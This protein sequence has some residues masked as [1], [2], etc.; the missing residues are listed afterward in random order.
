MRHVQGIMGCCTDR[1]EGWWET[2]ALSSLDAGLT[3]LIRP[4]AARRG[5]FSPEVTKGAYA[6]LPRPSNDAPDLS[7]LSQD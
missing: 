4:A 3:V 2:I 5:I 6:D 1:A 7:L